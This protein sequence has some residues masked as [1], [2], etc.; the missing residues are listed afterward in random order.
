VPVRGPL[1][2]AALVVACAAPR[3]DRPPPPAEVAASVGP[4]PILVRVPLEGGVPQAFRWPDV[5]SAIWRGTAPTPAITAALGF[6]DASGSLALETAQGAPVRLDLRVGRVVAAPAHA[7]RTLATA[8]GWSVFGAVG[9]DSIVRI[10]P[11][12]E[13]RAAVGAVDRVV[14]LRDGAVIAS[15]GAGTLHRV[16]PPDR[17]IT[18]RATVPGAQGIAASP[19]GDRIYAFGG[20]GVTALAGRDLTPVGR[21]TAT[22]VIAA[23]PTPSGDRLI[24]AEAGEPRL[25]I[26][27][28]YTEKT[29]ATVTLPAPADALR[30]DP[31]GRVVLVRAADDGRVVPVA[32]GTPRALPAVRSDWRPDLPTVAPDGTIVV[33]DGEDVAAVDPVD[34]TERWRVAGGASDLWVFVRW[35]G[36]RPRARGLDRPVE[37]AVDAPVDSAQ[38]ADAIDSVLAL[39]AEQLRDSVVP[40]GT[41]VPAAPP[42]P[43]PTAEG[44]TV[45]FAAVLSESRAREVAERVQVDGRAAR[46][47][48]SDRDGVT[49]WRV[50]LGPYP[51][52]EEADRVGRR[53][54]VAYWVFEGLP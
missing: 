51:T 46:V 4:E 23:V 31:L 33:A 32:I 35:D 16:R 13:W 5:D 37:F 27:D 24:Y 7:W 34:G 9:S 18:H 28:R 54:G 41:A 45:S 14:P 10:T 25:R 30:M 29:I 43:P 19:L 15:A 44:F 26:W 6:D 49:I 12:G 48:A 22:P 1:L 38:E 2:A 11:S 52:R 17:G 53:S 21:P 47:V 3:G 20:G 42:G 40:S 39:A 50:V 8:D 36:F